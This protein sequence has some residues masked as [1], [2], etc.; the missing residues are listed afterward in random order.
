[1]PHTDKINSV[2]LNYEYIKGYYPNSSQ[3]KLLYQHTLL[4]GQLVSSKIY[5]Q[6]GNT[7]HE[8]SIS[9]NKVCSAQ[10]FWEN[11]TLMSKLTSKKLDLDPILILR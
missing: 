10:S 2:S 6:N 11:G 9:D 8:L 4:E 1:M 5:H 7:L 3:T